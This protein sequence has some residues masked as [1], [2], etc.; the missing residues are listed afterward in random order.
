MIYRTL[1]L[2]G[3]SNQ[4]AV[5]QFFELNGDQL[6]PADTDLDLLLWSSQ[7]DPHT[8]AGIDSRLKLCVDICHASENKLQGWSQ[9]SWLDKIH[10]YVLVECAD[11]DQHSKIISSD[12]I[13]NRSKAFYQ[14]YKFLSDPVWYYTEPSDYVLPDLE[15]NPTKIFLMACKRYNNR[16]ARAVI[17][18]HVVTKYSHLGH[19]G[20]WP[21]QLLPSNRRGPELDLES[22][23]KLD[24]HSVTKYSPVHNCFYQ[25][26]YIS[27]YC[28]TL[29]WGTT[30]LVTEKTWDP[31][32]KGHFILP[33]G[34]RGLIQLIKNHGFQLPEFINYDYDLCDDDTRLDC[35]LQE[36]DRLMSMSLEQWHQ[37]WLDNLDLIK[38]NR[39]VFEKTPYRRID[40]EKFMSEQKL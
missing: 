20:H 15:K 37:H 7:I 25:D 23:M 34:H 9:V 26:S 38:H 19:I 40:F 24:S 33:Y 27:V 14:H 18:D 22:V 10:S 11:P 6:E 5:K 1:N 12:W 35:Y 39:S 28:E 21:H 30:Q 17:F 3:D 29:E 32:I 2:C 31:L 4:S 8:I 16:P 36:L 13:W